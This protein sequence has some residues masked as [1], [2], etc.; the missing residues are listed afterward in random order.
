MQVYL[1]SKAIAAIKVFAPEKDVRF[2][3]NGVNLEV[4]QNAVYL[5]ATNGNLMGCMRIV[6]ENKDVE[7][8]KPIKN[9]ILPVDMLKRIKPKR[10]QGVGITLG[11]PESKESNARPITLSYDGVTTSG[12]TLDGV[13]PDWQRVIPSNVTGETAQFD[14]QLIARLDQ[15]WAAWHGKES[16]R[17][18]FIGHSGKGSA[19]VSMWDEN[20]FGVI[21]P[22]DHE[23]LGQIPQSPPSWLS[24]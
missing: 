9:V 2:Y 13:F 12:T 1:D 7:V 14:P 18:M 8:N 15:A 5:I 4:H 22:L 16:V 21:M 3:L 20:F 10:L 11:E 23:R 6:Q 17:R 19:L 24:N